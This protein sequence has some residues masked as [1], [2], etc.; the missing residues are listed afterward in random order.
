[1]PIKTYSIILLTSLH[2]HPEVFFTSRI[3][4][5][6]FSERKVGEHFFPE[7]VSLFKHKAMHR[8]RNFIL[9][10]VQNV[11]KICTVAYFIKARTVKPAETAVVREW[12]CKYACC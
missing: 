12:L 2:I 6:N 9:L 4:F 11:K 8:K 5:S 3:K 10:L 7:F 1:M